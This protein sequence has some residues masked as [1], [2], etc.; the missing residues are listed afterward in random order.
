MQ[1]H[2]R[3]YVASLGGSPP[4]AQS[5]LFWEFYDVNAPSVTL[6]S[7]VI[8]MKLS[9]TA[10]TSWAAT[11]VMYVRPQVFSRILV[12]THALARLLVAIC[13][14]LSFRPPPADCDGAGKAAQLVQSVAVYVGGDIRH[15]DRGAKLGVS[16]APEFVWSNEA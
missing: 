7:G 5:F 14:F 8:D 16:P 1:G 9:Q 4:N 13:D 12:S 11:G 15:F 2:S 10:G 6:Q 3:V